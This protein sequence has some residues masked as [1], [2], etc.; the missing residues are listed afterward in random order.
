MTSDKEETSFKLRVYAI[1]RMIPR[2]KMATYGQVRTV[3]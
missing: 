2:G 3:P 1:T